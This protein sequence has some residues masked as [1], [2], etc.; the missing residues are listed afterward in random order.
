MKIYNLWR[1]SVPLFLINWMILLFLSTPLFS[2][3]STIEVYPSNNL[4]LEVYPSINFTLEAYPSQ[5]KT[6]TNHSFPKEPKHK[7]H[8]LS[9]ISPPKL[10]LPCSYTDLYHIYAYKLNLITK[11]T[12]Y[13]YI[14]AETFK[15][16]IQISPSRCLEPF[17]V[18]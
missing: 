17:H 7:Q 18:D 2:T 15:N 8:T 12:V 1:R 5:P 3:L 10:I 11:S 13:P 6:T 14:S 16:P 9:I 4:Q